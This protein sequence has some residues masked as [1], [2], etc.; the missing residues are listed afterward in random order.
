MR[1]LGCSKKQQKI[2]VRKQRAKLVIEKMWES[3]HKLLCQ[4]NI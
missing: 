3:H 4:V 2:M 1:K